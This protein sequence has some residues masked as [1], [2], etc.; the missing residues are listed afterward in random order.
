MKRIAKFYKV[1]W[2]QFQKD[3]VNTFGENNTIDMKEVRNIYDHIKI[4]KRATSGSAGYDFFI[5][6]DVR[7]GIGETAKIPTGIRVEMDPEWVLKCYPRSGLGFKYQFN[8]VNQTGIIDQDYFYSDNEG[9]IFVKVK[10]NGDKTININA[11]D[12]F[13]Q[14]IFTEF[15][16]TVDDD[17]DNKRNGGFGST[18]N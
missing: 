12:K 13:I 17:I 5:P 7:L 3:Y 2:E 15:G 10:N 6:F 11:G 1:S 16:I 14:G 9:H 4:P 8:L 18:G